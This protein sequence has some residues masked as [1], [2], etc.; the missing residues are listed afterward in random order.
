MSEVSI[1]DRQVDA[2]H[3]LGLQLVLDTLD[4]PAFALDAD[5]R[6]VAW[7]EQFSELLGVTR[8]EALGL[9]ELG[10]VLYDDDQRNLTLAEKIV[11]EP[12]DTHEA[13]DGVDPADETYA[14]LNGEYVY[15][16]TSTIDGTEI[17]FVAAPVFEDGALV[18]VIEIIQDI[19]KSARYQSELQD[20]FTALTETIREYE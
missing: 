14:L 11:R 6:V 10:S 4:F 3:G 16:D 13:F 5:S 18:G 12:R 8:T 1:T 7:D 15:E 20:L 19:A 17:W 2:D 9:T